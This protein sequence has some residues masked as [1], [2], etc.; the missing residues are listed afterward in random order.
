MP[1]LPSLV[2]DRDHRFRS[3]ITRAE[4]EVMKA[5]GSAAASYFAGYLSGLRTGADAF[6]SIRFSML[7]R[8]AEVLPGDFGDGY[9]AGLL[10]IEFVS[11]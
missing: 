6:G 11:S 3:L 2:P 7:E 10:N 4:V 5:S 1:D 8:E 9:R